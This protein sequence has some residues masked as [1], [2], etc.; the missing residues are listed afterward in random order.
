MKYRV[1]VQ[2]RALADLEAGYE[3]VALQNQPAATRWLN[4][5]LTAI[6][7]LSDFPERC[8]IARK[9]ELVGQEIRQLIFGRRP[10]VWRALFIIDSDAV[11][12]LC[13]RHGA[14]Q[15]ASAED[16]SEGS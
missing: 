16:L 13:I 8:S 11:R 3:Y 10:G 1:I 5:F 9:S 14:R 7:D 4:R 6:E 12:V 2:P 15:D